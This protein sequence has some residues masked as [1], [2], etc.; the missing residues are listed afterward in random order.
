MGAGVGYVIDEWGDE[1]ADGAE[2]VGG[3]VADGAKAVG[4]FIGDLF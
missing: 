2:A 1:I 3:A 4:N